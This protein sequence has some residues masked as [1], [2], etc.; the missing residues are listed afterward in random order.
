M[1]QQYSKFVIVVFCFLLFWGTSLSAVE[2]ENLY[3]VKVGIEDQSSQKR[4]GAF[5]QGFKEI[6][7]RRSGSE[8]VLSSPEVQKA[9]SKV[10]AYVQRFE[11]EP[12]ND[13]EAEFPLNLDLRFEPRL[14]DQLIQEAGM[15]IWGSNRPLTMLWLAVE[16]NFNREVIR[17]SEEFKPLLESINEQAKRRGIPI[18]FPLMDLEDQLTVTKSDVW[19]MFTTPIQEASVRYASDSIIAGKI[20]QLGENWNARLVYINQG[21]ESRIEFNE[22]SIEGVYST[23]INQLAEVLCEKYCVVEQLQTDQLVMQVSN[24]KSFAEVKA[25]QNYLDSLSSIRKIEVNRVANT[26]IRFNVSLLGE[27]ASL[28]EDIRLGQK[29]IEEDLPNVDPFAIVDNRANENL[30]ENNASQLTDVETVELDLKNGSGV[31]ATTD[32]SVSKSVNSENLNTDGV[33][34]EQTKPSIIYYR[35]QG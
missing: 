28:E 13:A 15:P 9:Y 23:L 2:V 24:V 27:L 12:I 16:E 35:W 31:L 25:L 30:L 6:V 4:W 33:I 32:S 1:F 17:E 5:V 18:I 34:T 3:Q 19:G 29:M 8:D 7:V 21:E 22:S 10:S 14:I 20:S 11:Y 26:H